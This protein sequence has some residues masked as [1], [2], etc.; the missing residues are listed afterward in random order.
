MEVRKRER[1]IFCSIT[2][3][4]FPMV[5]LSASVS[6]TSAERLVGVKPATVI[7]CSKSAGNPVCASAAVMTN[8][9]PNR[10]SRCQSTRSRISRVASRYRKAASYADQFVTRYRG[11]G[12]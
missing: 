4:T 7:A 12:I 9:P 2:V 3:G 1:G 11:F 6:G 5:L 10:T 8:R